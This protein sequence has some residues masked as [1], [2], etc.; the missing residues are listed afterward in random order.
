MKDDTT[1]CDAMR[2]KKRMS[3]TKRLLHEESPQVGES[4][5]RRLGNVVRAAEKFG[6][7]CTQPL[8]DQVDNARASARIGSS[9]AAT[10]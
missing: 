6:G 3:T 9:E 7:R 4:S 1:V 10:K 8:Q 2:L 5:C